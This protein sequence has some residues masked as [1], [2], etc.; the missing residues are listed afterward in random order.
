MTLRRPAER[1]G[2][3]VTPRVRPAMS[4]SERVNDDVQCMREYFSQ[5]IAFAESFAK[6]FAPPSAAGDNTSVYQPLNVTH[7][8]RPDMV[9]NVYSLLDFWLQELCRYQQQHRTLSMTFS[10]FKKKDKSR[11][12]D[13][14]RYRK[15]ISNIAGVDLRA[16]HPSFKS[17]DVLR[18]V[19][20]AFIHR[21]GH[22]KEKRI[23]ELVT[24]TP[25]ISLE[26]TL[27]VVSDRY[28]FESLDHASQFMQAIAQA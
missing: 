21:G 6:A 26:T 5:L 18:E 9:C 15:Y 22:A 12:S 28:I 16:V 3:A 1:L 17:L 19:R 27:I 25:G 4:I 24:K 20:I 13:L 7:L 23:R 14:E 2:S 8:V 10:D 11:T